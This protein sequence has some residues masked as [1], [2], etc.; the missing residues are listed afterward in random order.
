VKDVHFNVKRELWERFLEVFPYKGEPTAFFNRCI[1]AAVST[2]VPHDV[3]KEVDD[4][5]RKVKEAEGRRV[6]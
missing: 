6:E 4:I 1:E 2:R 5:I 3:V